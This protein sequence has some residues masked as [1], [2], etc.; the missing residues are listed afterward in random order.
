MF[1]IGFAFGFLVAYVVSFIIA[2]LFLS[3]FSY[4][5]NV[6]HDGPQHDYD[7]HM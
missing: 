1:W 2:M 3:F 6:E 4:K 5:E 7:W